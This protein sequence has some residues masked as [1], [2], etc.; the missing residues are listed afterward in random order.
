MYRVWCLLVLAIVAISCTDDKSA[1]D[2][3]PEGPPMIRQVLMDENVTTPTRVEKRRVFAFGTHP[4]ASESQVLPAMNAP[5]IGQ[6]MRIVVDEL[7]IGNNLEEVECRGVV[8]EDEFDRVPLRAD[9]DDIARCAATDDVLPRTCT[10]DERAI[11]I[12]KNAAGCPRQTDIVDMGEPVGILDL[13]EDGGADNTRFIAGSVGITCD[14]TLVVPINPEASYWNP[15]GTQNRPPLPPIGQGFEGLG[16]AI[17][18]VPDGPLPTNADCQ[19]AFSEEVVDKQNVTVCAPPDGDIA[20]ACTPG[21]LTAFTFRSEVLTITPLG[22]DLG[23]EPFN[24]GQ[25]GVKRTTMNAQLVANT[26]LAAAS[27]A[28]ITMTQNGAAFTAF[29]IT[30]P[31]P[32]TIQINFTGLLAAN[33]NYVIVI[34]VTVTDSF[35]KGI[36]APLMYRFMTGAT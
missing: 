15:S 11:C 29:T 22:F 8:D 27:V 26:N 7:L 36:T 12:C 21:D 6:N 28:N 31:M 16:P 24:D 2:L 4:L 23:V 25:T 10:P 3:N 18:L 17:V 35:G 32:N 14:G 33:A 1:T 34:P 9:P 19:L 30:T 20:Q 5:A 13:N